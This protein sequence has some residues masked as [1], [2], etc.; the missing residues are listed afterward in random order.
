MKMKSAMSKILSSKIVL[1][2]IFLVSLFNI[3]GYVI[4]GHIEAVMYFIVLGILTRYF[5]KNMII[6]LGVP[7]ILVNLY[8]LKDASFLKKSKENFANSTDGSGNN[9]NNSTNQNNTIK[10]IN[11]QGNP[12]SQ[13]LPI[14]PL[15]GTVQS[16]ESFEVGRSKKK[17]GYDIDYASTV[18]D[19]YD[20]LNKIIGGEGIKKLTEDTQGLM[21]QQLQLAEAMKGMGPLIKGM[22][23]LMEQ[24]QGLLGGMK[25]GGGMEKITNMAKQLT[26]S[27]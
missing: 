11:N 6:V 12:S 2:I 25:E 16:N 8:V 18:E 10:N 14:T 21:K 20:E 5:S 22:A 23:P 9:V 1:N 7:L 24:A 26:G 4:M 15:D 13:G 19:A 17:N 27:M 3:L